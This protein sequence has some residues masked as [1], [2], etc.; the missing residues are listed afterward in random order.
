VQG[1]QGS[2]AQKRVWDKK[3][4][5]GDPKRGSNGGDGRKKRKK[6]RHLYGQKFIIKSV[7]GKNL[8]L[9]QKKKR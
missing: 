3:R 2:M 5:W 4:K 1:V 7:K 9:H 8:L 6:E